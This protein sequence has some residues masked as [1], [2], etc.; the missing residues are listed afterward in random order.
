MED[1]PL[2]NSIIIK[3]YIEFLEQNYPDLD[4]NKLLDYSAI[5]T[6]ELEDRGHWLTQK[7]VNRFQ[8]YVQLVTA[9]PNIAREAGRYIASPTSSQILRKSI[10]GFLSPAIVYWVVEKVASTLTRHLTIK[11][12]KLTANKIEIIAKPHEFVKEEPFQ[13]ENRIGM[14]EAGRGSIYSQIRSY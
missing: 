6:H 3:T 8:E 2:Y 12:N 14:F 5:A 11:G 7:Q 13:C 4:I 9:N 10:A 1:I